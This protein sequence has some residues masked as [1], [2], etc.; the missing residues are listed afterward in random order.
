[1]LQRRLLYVFFLLLLFCLFI[2]NR[3]TEF[4]SVANEFSSPALQARRINKISIWKKLIQ[5]KSVAKKLVC[6]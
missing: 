5:L 1:M 6:G 4:E 3:L 2:I